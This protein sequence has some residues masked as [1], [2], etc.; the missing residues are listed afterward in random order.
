MGLLPAPEDPEP[1]PVEPLPEP[2]E[3]EPPPEVPPPVAALP[4]EPLPEAP[5]PP[6][7]PLLAGSSVEPPD[8]LAPVEPEALVLEPEEVVEVVD[9]AA[10]WASF[11][12]EVFVGGMML[13]VLLGTASE[14]LEL[15]PQA[16][17][18]R[19]QMV[20]TVA[21]MATREAREAALTAAPCA[22]RRWDSR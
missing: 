6:L 2:P 11:S 12:I 20:R 15:P 5:V 4:P 18:V 10:A 7:A 8:S 14:A 13:G 17:S 19:A 9:T 3:E 1:P 16:P 21:P 22:G